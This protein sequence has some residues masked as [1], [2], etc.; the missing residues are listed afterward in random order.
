MVE[1]QISYFLSARCACQLAVKSVVK[2]A[3]SPTTVSA[4]NSPFYT[5]DNMSREA[6]FYIQV[7]NSAR[8]KHFRAQR[9][10]ERTNQ[11]SEHHLSP[12]VSIQITL[13]TSRI[14]YKKALH[15]LRKRR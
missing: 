6:G 11:E 1:I 9:R 5:V 15:T 4:L 12:T 7:P 14:E 13:Q 8:A 3:D 10:K 2:P